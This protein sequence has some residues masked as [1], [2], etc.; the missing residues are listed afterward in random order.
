MAP[1]S[2]VL[3]QSCHYPQGGI[4]RHRKSTKKILRILKESTRFPQIITTSPE[5]SILII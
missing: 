3:N 2:R 1:S 5:D 4:H